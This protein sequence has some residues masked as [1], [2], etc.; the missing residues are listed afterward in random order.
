MHGCIKSEQLLLRLNNWQISKIKQMPSVSSQ[1][2]QISVGDVSV[3]CSCSN[4]ILNT[5][6]ES[7]SLKGEHVCE[8]IF[9]AKEYADALETQTIT[10]SVGEKYR[11]DKEIVVIYHLRPCQI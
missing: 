1:P 4:I 6:D 10:P 7:L 9:K 2:K 11:N 5:I 3:D 8:R